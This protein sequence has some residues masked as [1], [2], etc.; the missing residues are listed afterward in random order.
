MNNWSDVS[1]PP[2]D[3]RNSMDICTHTHTHTHT[4]TINEKKI[5]KINN[6][7]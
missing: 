5:L 3:H 7:T 1:A 6:D 4:H 2:E